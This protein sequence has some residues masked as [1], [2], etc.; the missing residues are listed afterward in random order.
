MCNASLSNYICIFKNVI[1]LFKII[2]CH[3]AISCIVV[4]DYF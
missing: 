3:K 4:D 1:L 2:E